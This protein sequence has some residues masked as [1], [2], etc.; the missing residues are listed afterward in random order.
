ML[1]RVKLVQKLELPCLRSPGLLDGRETL[2]K[3]LILATIAI[4]LLA[5]GRQFA[6][7]AHPAET[8]VAHA[9]IKLPPHLGRLGIQ[10]IIS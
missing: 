4:L 6:I 3:V 1:E 9:A 8:L 7:A 10:L 2:V 5:V